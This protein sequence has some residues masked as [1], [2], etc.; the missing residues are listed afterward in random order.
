MTYKDAI[1]VIA[2]T[3]DQAKT[4]A[5]SLVQTRGINTDETYIVR[6]W[7][8]ADPVQ[9]AGVHYEQITE[10]RLNGTVIPDELESALQ[11]VYTQ[12][13][14]REIWGSVSG[15]L[16]EEADETGDVLEEMETPRLLK[17]EDQEIND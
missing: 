4:M 7:G 1:I 5:R 15:L 10:I 13:P 12:E 6:V 9:L 8:G 2:P 3:R 14:K 11:G 16:I 17:T